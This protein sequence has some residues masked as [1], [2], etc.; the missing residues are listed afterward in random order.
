MPN[1]LTLGRK[2]EVLVIN[3]GDKQYKLPLVTSLPY[4]KAKKLLK[5]FKG[6]N[7][8]ELELV[9]AFI[10]TVK[11]YIPSEVLED[12]TMEDI[13]TLAVTWGGVKPSEEEEKE[14]MLGE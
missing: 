1:E 9:D 6:E 4:K 5:L 2:T 14:D 11:D 12:L 10:E 7:V 3:I 13:K 8:D